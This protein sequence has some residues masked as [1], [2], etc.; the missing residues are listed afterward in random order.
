MVSEKQTAFA[1]AYWEMTLQ[2]IRLNWQVSATL[3]SACCS[4]FSLTAPSLASMMSQTQHAIGTVFE[5]GLG[6]IHRATVLNARR[7]ATVPLR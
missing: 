1:Q 2:M 4:P 3:F 5:K 7:L 6:P